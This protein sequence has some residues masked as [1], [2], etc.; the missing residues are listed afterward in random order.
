[1]PR[2]RLKEKMKHR[3]GGLLYK[4]G[5]VI[6][7]E[8]SDAKKIM[9]KLDP[10][11]VPSE[12]SAPAPVVVPNEEPKGEPKKEEE[13]EEPSEPA[14]S[15][16]EPTPSEDSKDEESE[17]SSPLSLGHAGQG[18]WNV[19]KDNKPINDVPLSEGA[20]RAMLESS[21]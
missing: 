13:S 8:E 3:M 18:M 7:M 15:P 19:L 16:N 20:A 2:Y 12:S 9:G 11:D 10:L 5:D 4:A 17:G 1:M 14:S 21:Q 6:V